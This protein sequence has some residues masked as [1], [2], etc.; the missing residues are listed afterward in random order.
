[1]SNFAFAR[2]DET[3]TKK[4]QIFSRFFA[5]ITSHRIRRSAALNIYDTAVAVDLPVTTLLD[6]RFHHATGA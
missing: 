5:R 3:S 2:E 6:G 4:T 1:M